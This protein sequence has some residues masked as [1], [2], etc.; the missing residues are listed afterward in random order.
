MIIETVKLTILFLLV[1]TFMRLLGKTLLSQWTAYDLVTIFFLSYSALGAVK[2]SGFIHAVISVLIIAALY[3]FLSKISLF[4]AFTKLI[5]GEPTILIKHGKII[6]K[7]LKKIRY[8]LAELLSTVRALGYPDISDIEYAILEPNGKI[9]VIPTGELSPLT[10]KH[11]NLNIDYTGLPITLIAEGRIQFGNLKLIDKD[12]KWL[13]DNLKHNGY[14]NTKN[15]FYA[16]VKD[17]NGEIKFF[18]YE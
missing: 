2:I 4:P 8:S 17:G 14:N 6:H 9:S 5:I 16:F 13:M 7:N 1:F 15:I 3:L 18:P 11:L 10:P 12:K